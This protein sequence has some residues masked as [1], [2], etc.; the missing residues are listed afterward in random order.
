M[1]ES[2]IWNIPSLPDNPTIAVAPF[3]TEQS[4][5]S[6][7]CTGRVI[8]EI[9]TLALW[10]LPS[11]NMYHHWL[12]ARDAHH[13]RRNTPDTGKYARQF[14]RRHG[15]EVVI[16]GT[17]TYRCQ[18][19]TLQLEIQVLQ[20]E[21]T[22]VKPLCERY[23][24][25]GD[26]ETLPQWL[27]CHS[28]H[29]ANRILPGCA[30]PCS[31]SIQLLDAPL[32]ALEMVCASL[33]YFSLDAVYDSAKDY[34]QK[35][36]KRAP[37]SAY[38]RFASTITGDEQRDADFCREIVGKNSDFVPAYFPDESVTSPDM[39]ELRNAK[40]LYLQGLSRV[41]LNMH[42]YFGLREICVRQGDAKTLIPFAKLHTVRGTFS[43]GSSQF[44]DTFL[45]CMEKAR[46]HEQYEMARQLFEAAMEIID[47]PADQASLLEKRGQIEEWDE[48][49]ERALWFYEQSLQ[50]KKNIALMIHIADMYVGQ[51]RV[52]KAE[53]LYRHVLSM[54]K[55]I[56]RTRRIEA[57]FG[58]AR[59]YE[60]SGRI[61]QARA[62]YERL[63]KEPASNGAIYPL[64][65]YI[66]NWLRRHPK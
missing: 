23:I 45:N 44:G 18:R 60:E 7:P 25:K 4:N 16:T 64:L 49:I 42:G 21:G 55:K 33:D 48:D 8:S 41:P 14:M 35:A 27:T 62:I 58:I 53:P 2:E 36:K 20:Q 29:I 63:S 11:L 10:Q 22:G 43:S 34:L 13:L 66:S 6:L 9:I 38:V 24:A 31:E 61:L 1:L 47:D 56:G 5:G 26:Y 40:D 65:F 52:D 37:D 28:M 3:L 50:L 39:E 12:L 51:G 32:D 15:V 46:Q 30:P 57:E 54:G 19:R 17:Y 59:C